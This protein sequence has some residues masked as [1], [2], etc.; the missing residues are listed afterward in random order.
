M[1]G[2]NRM[3]ASNAVFS[4][5]PRFVFAPF[6]IIAIVA[7]IMEW[8]NGTWPV[9]LAWI[10][11]ASYVN[12][13]WTSC[14]HEAA[15]QTLCGSRRFSIC[16]G[17]AVGTLILVPYNTYRESHIRHHAYLNK[18]TDWELW[19]YSDPTSP[20]WFRRMFC[21]LEVPF[22][23]F[24]SPIA[25]GRLY[26]HKNSPL[27]NSKM[28]RTIGRE[29][30]AILLVWGSAFGLVA[31]TS[32]WRIFLMVWVIPHLITG[33]YQ[34]FRKFTEHLGMQSYDPLLGTRTVIGTN[35]VTRLLTYLNFDIFV[36]GPHHRHPRYRHEQLCDKMDEYQNENP[37]TSYPVFTTYWRAILHTLPAVLA[38]PGVGM[39]AGAPAPADEKPHG[40]EEFSTDVTAE[41]LAT[42]D[43]AEE[44]LVMDHEQLVM[45]H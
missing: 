18:P 13:C 40:I 7:L 4:A 35:W 41:I 39:N 14:F 5:I 8:P 17:R 2:T 36:H 22:G 19:P 32:S 20:L 30:L 42:R 9:Q 25:Y 28:R 38:N 34:T 26:F 21:W 23:A 6:G 33:V 43:T 10:G 27:T 3:A 15:H 24:T 45:S 44:H 31:Y 16:V 37:E 1:D 11:V 29:Y 12:F